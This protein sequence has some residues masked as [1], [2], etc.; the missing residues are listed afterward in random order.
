[1][2]YK[3]FDCNNNWASREK[4]QLYDRLADTGTTTHIT[5]R[6]EAFAAYQEIPHIAIKGVGPIKTHTIGRGTVFL[7]SECD[8]QSYTFEL[9]NVLHVPSNRNSFGTTNVHDV[10]TVGEEMWFWI[11]VERVLALL[12]FIR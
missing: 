5:H 8:G 9:N 1:M 4:H 3:N 10:R 12:F 7:Q 11:G 6:R 2:G